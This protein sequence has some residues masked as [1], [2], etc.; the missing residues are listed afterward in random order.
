MCVC[1]I[2]TDVKLLIEFTLFAGGQ[3][4]A[5]RR[6][7]TKLV[8]S[9]EAVGDVQLCTCRIWFELLNKLS[10][11][12]TVV[13]IWN[14]FWSFTICFAASE[15]SSEQGRR[16]HTCNISFTWSPT[17]SSPTVIYLLAKL[18]RDIADDIIAG[19]IYSFWCR[20]W[21]RWPFWSTSIIRRMHR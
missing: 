5:S 20:F 8:M 2:W 21:T 14:Q 12:C 17:P 6:W 3:R 16:K 1:N 15:P 10:C 11:C 4:M 19:F 13:A 7:P 9:W 18:R